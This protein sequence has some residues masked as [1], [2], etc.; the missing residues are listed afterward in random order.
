MSTLVGYKT[1]DHSDVVGASPVSTAPATSSFSA[2]HLSSMDWVV[3][4]ARWHE[5]HLNVLT[6][7]IVYDGVDGAEVFCTTILWPLHFKFYPMIYWPHWKD[8]KK[9]HLH[10]RSGTHVINN[11]TFWFKHAG[12]FVLL[13]SK[14]KWSNYYNLLHVHQNCAVIICAKCVVIWYPI[15]EL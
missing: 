13:P 8:H 14:S 9:K 5:K 3:T 15:M 11:A 12:N 7:I 1:V 2:S 4:T 6:V 10:F